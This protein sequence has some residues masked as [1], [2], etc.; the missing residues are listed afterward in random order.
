MGI[1]TEMLAHHYGQQPAQTSTESAE[2]Q[3][4]RRQAEIERQNESRQV[5]RARERQEAKKGK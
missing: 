4:A 1:G 3:A 2:Q 5:R